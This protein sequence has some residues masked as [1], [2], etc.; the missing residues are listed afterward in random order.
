[1][2]NYRPFDGSSHDEAMLEAEGLEVLW[3]R[4]VDDELGDKTGFV[5]AR[6]VNS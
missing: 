2:L 3:R 1:M 6:K 5:L 4:V